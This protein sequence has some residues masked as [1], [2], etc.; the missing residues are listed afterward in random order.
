MSFTP[1]TW[2]GRNKGMRRVRERILP[3]Q[4]STLRISE[5]ESPGRHDGEDQARARTFTSRYCGKYVRSVIAVRGLPTLSGIL[6]Q[7]HT[8]TRG[9]EWTKT[10]IYSILT[11]R[12]IRRFCMGKKQQARSSAGPYREC[13][14]GNRR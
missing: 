10:G 2:G 6:M 12:Y 1:T 5:G 14:P 3:L 13:L 7:E 11:T 9:K 8:G 4:Q